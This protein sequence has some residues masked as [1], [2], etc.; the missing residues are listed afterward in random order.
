MARYL[1]PVVFLAATLGVGW[2]NRTHGASKVLVP[3]IDVFAPGDP[4]Q[5]GE[6]SVWVLAGA[7][8][9]VSV[10]T[11]LEHYRAARAQ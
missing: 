6:R 2:Y 5:L 3:L 11:V 8:A 4:Q 10:L 7:T 9:V 1:A